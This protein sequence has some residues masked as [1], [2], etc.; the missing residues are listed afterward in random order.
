[1]ATNLTTRGML[2]GVA[3]SAA[4]VGTFLFL[5]SRHGS[6]DSLTLY[7][8]VDIREVQ[9]A[10]NDSDRIVRMFVQEGDFVR[11][12]ELLAELDSRRYAASAD[13]ARRRV[14]A[15]KQVLTR[16]LNGSR[17]QGNRPSAFD[18][19]SSTC[20]DA[21][22][23]DHLSLLLGAPVQTGHLSE[24]A[25]RRSINLVPHASILANADDRISNAHD[26]SGAASPQAILSNPDNEF[27]GR[28]C[29]R[30]SWSE[31]ELGLKGVDLI[32]GHG[33]QDVKES[34]ERQA[35]L[36]KIERRKL[37]DVADNGFSHITGV[38]QNLVGHGKR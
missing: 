21:R 30:I 25:R 2:V 26:S 36:G 31:F 11:P 32:G 12:G 6:S 17:P 20:N 9:V 4:V 28:D 1:M 7:G 5:H 35:V 19:A 3:L 8:N 23:R 38:E 13:Q 16:L 27:S 18:N 22:C 34:I 29:Q 15:Q 24:D 14:E 33:S 10:F 37:L